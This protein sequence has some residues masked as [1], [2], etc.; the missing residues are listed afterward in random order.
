MFEHS[1]TLGHLITFKKGF[2]LG[3]YLSIIRD[4]K[5]GLQ[6]RHDHNHRWPVGYLVSL[7]WWWPNQSVSGSSPLHHNIQSEYYCRVTGSLWPFPS[8]GIH[9][10]CW[11]VTPV[12]FLSVDRLWWHWASL[13]HVAP[14]QFDHDSSFLFVVVEGGI[15]VGWWWMYTVVL[16]NPKACQN[17]TAVQGYHYGMKCF[18]SLGDL[19]V[20]FCFKIWETG[21]ILR[22]NEQLSHNVL[23]C[24]LFSSLL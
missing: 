9:L 22:P 14:L 11:F 8:A 12:A 23:P 4:V 17:S 19:W 6:K 20:R 2:L 1:A 18:S 10:K 21:K 15:F 5:H 7:A 3:S 13:C 16:S 24:C